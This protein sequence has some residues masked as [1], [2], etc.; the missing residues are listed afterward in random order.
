MGPYAVLNYQQVIQTLIER[1]CNFNAKNNDK[2]NPSDYAY[3][4]VL[5]NKHGSH[6]SVHYSSNNTYDAL[7]ETART[8][9]EVN[10]KSRVV[11]QQARRA[12]YGQIDN[13]EHQRRGLGVTGTRRWRSGSATT[14]ASD[15][16]DYEGGPSTSAP[17]SSQFS[18]HSS[19][20]S[21]PRAPPSN[22]TVLTPIP[23]SAANRARNTS[24]SSSQAPTHTSRPSYSSSTTNVRSASRPGSSMGTKSSSSAKTALSPIASR[25]LERDA[26][27]MAEYRVR[28]ESHSSTN[29]L[30]TNVSNIPAVGGQIGTYTPATESS[31]S[32]V[33]VSDLRAR[34]I[35]RSLR[36]S[37]SAASL[38]PHHL[39]SI[40]SVASDSI[41]R[42]RAGTLNNVLGSSGASTP[43]TP[44]TAS[45]LLQ[46]LKRPVLAVLPGGRSSD[47]TL[48]P[49]GHTRRPSGSLLR[50][51]AAIRTDSM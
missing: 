6:L 2:F 27:A 33:Q 32:D 24:T 29:T 48:I 38:R 21:L 23:S 26:G 41:P 51:I 36:P 3:S 20:G 5:H 37:L 19:S 18:G 8:R 42:I 15:S 39:P 35:P 31:F 50:D 1:G 47:H 28:S 34:T 46:T 22:G 16:T 40:T 10:K 11:Q 45:T 30:E 44:P 12:A 14:S 7:Q 13:D 9:F 17:G 49:N 43:K 4:C 25:M